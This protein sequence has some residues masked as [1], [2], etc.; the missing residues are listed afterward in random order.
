MMYM[1]EAWLVGGRTWYEV[2]EEPSRGND[3]GIIN[4]CCWTG[5]ITI[6]EGKGRPLERDGPW[7]PEKDIGINGAVFEPGCIK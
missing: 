6:C 3:E 5:G 2:G 1:G 4:C 7:L